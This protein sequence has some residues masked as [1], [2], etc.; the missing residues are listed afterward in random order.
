M[1]TASLKVRGVEGAAAP[2]YLF[3]DQADDAGDAWRMQATTSDTFAIGSDKAS[4]GTIIDYITITNGANAAASVVAL[5]G[6]LTVGDDLSLT[7]DSA[8]FNMGAGND[9]TI[10]HDGTEGATIAGNP[11]TLDSGGDITLDAEDADIFLKDGGTLFGTLTNSSGE[12]VIKSSSSGTTAATFAGANVTFAGTVDATTDFTVGSTVITDDSIV[13]TPS[14]S[15]TVTIAGA[16]H[17]ILNVTTVDAAGTAADVNIDA[18]G[19][20]VLDAADAAG[21]IFKIAGTAQLSVIDGAILPTTDND[22][23][24]GSSSYQFKDAHINGTLEADAIT[25]GGTNVVTGS[26][27]T[28]LGTISA[29]VWEGTDVAVAHGGTG[30]SSLTDGGVLLGSGTS[31]VTAMAVLADS[32]MI[33][34]DGTTDPVAESGATLRTSI[35]V[36]TGDSPQF[37]AIELGHASD[38]TIARSGSGAITVEGTQVLLAGAALTGSTIDAT[39]DFTIG[40]TVITNGVI[41]DTS[42]LSIAAAVDL[43]ANTLTSTGSMQI[44]T[45]DYSDG[46]LAMTIADG[47]GVTF[48]QNVSLADA[49]NVSISTPLLANADHT[50]TGITA[51]M[52]AGAAIAAFDLVC[53]HTTTQEVNVADASAVATARAIGIAPAAIS[54]TATGTVLLKGFI[55]D[56]T[57]NWTT[58][59]VLYLSETAGE[60]THTAPTTDGAFVQTV[61]IALE[62]DVVYINPSLDIIEHA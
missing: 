25:I 40:D 11:L 42:G 47:G 35:G 19:E 5:G 37:T 16:T 3:A 7:S 18:D 38:T 12:L 50:T 27:I 28:T 31:A 20:I 23:D 56:D 8:V 48:A 34:G 60:M 17:G 62:P 54:D 13:M 14:T 33:V 24:L 10:T 22:I 59:S 9:F 44:R 29:G 1:D 15:D 39:T 58:G 41:T 21:T 55:R 36:G 51:E 52:L 4:A 30:A 2:I 45:I 46:D 61:G 53:I 49:A 57:W 32:E 26:L 6:D 43:G